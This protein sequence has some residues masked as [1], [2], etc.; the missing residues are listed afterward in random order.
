MGDLIF[1]RYYNGKEFCADSVDDTFNTKRVATT[2][3]NAYRARGYNARVVRGDY[4]MRR[5]VVYHSVEY[6]RR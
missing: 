1:R 3:A 5:Y 6:S 2:R 4:G